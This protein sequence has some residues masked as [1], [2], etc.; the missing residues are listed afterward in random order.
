MPLFFTYLLLC[1]VL[2]KVYFHFFMEIY[3][4]YPFCITTVIPL[5]LHLT[6]PLLSTPTDTQSHMLFY[7]LTLPII[8]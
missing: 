1:A 8:K 2:H 4:D 3:V 6:F 5:V 7:N